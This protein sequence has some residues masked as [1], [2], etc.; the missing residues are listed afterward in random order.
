M[1]ASTPIIST[2][3]KAR[4]VCLRRARCVGNLMVLID[5]KPGSGGGHGTIT[6][7]LP[8]DIGS[9]SDRATPDGSYRA[10]RQVAAIP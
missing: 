7:S 5:W 3:V 1:M 4:W 6:T 9:R 10:L 8:G 2:S